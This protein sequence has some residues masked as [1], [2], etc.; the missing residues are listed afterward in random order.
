M[1]LT[2][3]AFVRRSGAAL[4]G[5]G[6]SSTFA[7]RA[8][9]QSSDTLRIALSARGFR[10]L[11]PARSIQGADEWAIIHMFDTLVDMPLG[12]FPSSV[13]EVQP[14]L[15]QSWTASE[16]SRTW[17]FKLR[18]DVQ[19]H[20]GYGLLTSEDV[21]FTFDRL[22][23][24]EELGVRSAL[25][26]NL[27]SVTADAPDTVTLQL[28]LPD[29]LFIMGTLLHH[30]AS[31]VS[32]KAYEEK[33]SESFE[34]DPIG[35][36]PYQIESVAEDPSQGVLLTANPDYWGEAPLIPNL[37]T[38]YIADTTARTL[39]LMSGDIHMMEGVRA[40]G[41]VPSIE[42]Q[43]PGLHFDVA[44]PGSFFTISFNLATPPFDDVRVRQAIAYLIDRGQIAEAMAPFGQ[45]T[46]GINPPSFPGSFTA[47]SI[48]EE[49]RYER[50]VERAKELL[51]EAGHP[52]GFSFKAYTSQR[53]DYS[54]IMLMIQ[55]L[56]REG[57][58]EMELELRDHTAFHA[59]Q[60][61]GTNTLYQRSAAYPPV[62]TQAIS[63]QLAATSE[64][65]PDGSG[66]PNFSRYGVVIPGIDEMLAATMAEPDLEKR[67]ELVRE[68]EVKI[69]TD[70]PLLP[71]VTNGYMMVRAAD[72]DLG[73]EVK[74]GYAHWRLTKASFA[75]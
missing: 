60:A 17:T 24:P 53:E 26:E 73:Y 49:I 50:N 43:S 32:K 69:L 31:I 51:A 19:F 2:R 67:L 52:D 55:Q 59:D 22:L 34:R 3:R 18:P 33:G 16:D 68:M 8:I 42:A 37:Q 15:A 23:N 12:R 29:P 44:S 65:K 56:L 35:T 28:K 54:S 14:G 72:L 38:M 30:S 57:G 74:S 75:G 20:K 5:L 4:A 71:I 45:R 6:L 70:L 9:A 58:V 27:E 36:G 66:G 62:P 39:A 61:T 7:A 1:T 25:Y 41:W 48:P 13:D 64:V 46:W 63:E 40:P 21:K 10:T 11:D 47:E